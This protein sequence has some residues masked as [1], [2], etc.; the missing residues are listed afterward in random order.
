[1]SL[2]DPSFT[3]EH[4]LLLQ[5]FELE[6]GP[7]SEQFLKNLEWK[8]VQWPYLLDLAFQHRLLPVLYFFLKQNECLSQVPA[9]HVDKL[10]KAYYGALDSGIELLDAWDG[11][12]ENFSSSQ[13]PSTPLKGLDY[14]RSIHNGNP[15]LRPM[16]DGDILVSEKKR[17]EAKIVMK[18]MGYQLAETTTHHDIYRKNRLIIEVHTQLFADHFLLLFPEFRISEKSI[19]GSTFDKCSH[20]VLH[21]WIHRERP[22]LWMMDYYRLR[23]VFSGNTSE[24][25]KMLVSRSEAIL[26]NARKG[27][28]SSLFSCRRHK[29]LWLRIITNTLLEKAI[30]EP[31]KA[32][33][34]AAGL[35]SWYRNRNF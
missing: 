15:A 11:I 18:G 4:N 29:V 35:Y 27:N 12:S 14:I 16:T 19:S 23:K 24:S 8:K 1:M 22:A 34:I 20:S 25:M 13:I 10:T 9:E 7:S 31:A 32:F 33:E 17:E 28:F 21:W 2:F 30:T 5:T 3:A 26:K 6:P